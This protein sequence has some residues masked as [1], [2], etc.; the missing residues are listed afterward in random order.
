MKLLIALILI[1]V[2]IGLVFG[3]GT[4]YR[5]IKLQ[6]IWSR[7]ERNVEKDNYYM[8]TTIINNGTSTKTQSYY[9]EGTGKFISEDGSYIWFNGEYAYYINEASKTAKVL[10]KDEE[11]GIVYKESFASLYPGY[12]SNFFE[13]LLLAGD[14]S[15]KIKKQYYNGEKCIVITIEKENYTKTYWITDNLKN[16]VQA[17]IEFTN[18]DIYEYKYDIK[19]HATKLKDLELPDVSDYTVIDGATGEEVDLNSIGKDNNKDVENIIE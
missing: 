19:F 4:I 10:N 3:I 15:N 7:V 2:V 9:K 5:F 16:L 6:S 14:F 11:I 18:G 12:T 17:K 1:F 8:E 13:R